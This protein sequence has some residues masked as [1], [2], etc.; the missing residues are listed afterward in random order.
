MPIAASLTPIETGFLLL[1]R[2]FILDDAKIKRRV[3]SAVYYQPDLFA[4]DFRSANNHR[5]LSHNQS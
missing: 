4:T 1:E 5:P 3:S 2:P